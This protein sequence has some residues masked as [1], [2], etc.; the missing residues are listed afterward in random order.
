[1]QPSKSDRGV[2]AGSSQP[3]AASTDDTDLTSPANLRKLVLNYL[4]HH[5]YTDTAVA[6]AKDGIIGDLYGADS[7]NLPTSSD[8]AGLTSSSAR[9]ASSSSASASSS[10]ANA[11]AGS[12]TDSPL[13][14]ASSTNGAAGRQAHPLSAPPLSRDDSSMEIEVENLLPT[15]SEHLDS[16]S[17]A[18]HE[19]SNGYSNGT[20]NGRG[21]RTSAAAQE[22]E[23]HDE[24]DLEDAELASDLDEM[25]D[26][27]DVDISPDLTA[28]DLRAVRARKQI[29]DYIIAGHIRQAMDMINEHFPTVQMPR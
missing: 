21:P 12:G 4:L 14:A 3:P 29:K 15:S 7:T 19:Y 26:D 28:E 17:P 18:A 27:L 10:R 6:F 11:S 24:E 22:Q 20:S 2:G 13:R 16:T 23:E 25:Q 8:T 9:A 1:M 5:C